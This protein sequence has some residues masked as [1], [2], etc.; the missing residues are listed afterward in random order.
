MASFLLLLLRSATAVK[1]IFG[2]KQGKQGVHHAYKLVNLIGSRR[3]KK[4][5]PKPG[6]NEKQSA[7]N[8]PGLQAKLVTNWRKQHFTFDAQPNCIT[9]ANQG[10]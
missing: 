10:S 9:R 1:V 7:L 5:R 6:G 8:G 3:P 2:Q 4:H